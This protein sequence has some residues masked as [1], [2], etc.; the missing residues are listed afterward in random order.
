MTKFLS[1][2][3]LSFWIKQLGFIWLSPKLFRPKPVLCE[4]C[5]NAYFLYALICY[6]YLSLFYLKNG[7]LN[8]FQF[9]CNLLTI[10]L[11]NK[12]LRSY[13]GC[14]TKHD[15]WWIVLNVLNVFFHSWLSSL[16]PKRIIK[17]LYGSHIIVR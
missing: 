6:R 1:C 13:K 12:A 5:L 14:P 17:I 3:C 9:C 4:Y 2:L 15:N 16:I 7:Q 10:I 8:S 11:Y